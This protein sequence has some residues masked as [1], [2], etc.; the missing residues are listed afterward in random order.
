MMTVIF[1]FLKLTLKL[2]DLHSH[3]IIVSDHILVPLD[4][5]FLNNTRS[6]RMRQLDPL[7]LTY[8]SFNQ[9]TSDQIGTYVEINNTP[10]MSFTTI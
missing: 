7:L 1:F 8:E 4:L 6:Q 2:P 10:G 3:A 5:T 9:Y